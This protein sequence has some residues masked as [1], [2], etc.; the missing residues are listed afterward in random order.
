MGDGCEP[1][2][3]RKNNPRLQLFV[4]K[5]HAPLSGQNADWLTDRYTP[6]RRTFGPLQRQNPHYSS[7]QT[8]V[9]CPQHANTLEFLNFE[10]VQR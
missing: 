6:A 1:L 8:A 7:R 5:L 10:S 2:G 3:I 4:P 9:R